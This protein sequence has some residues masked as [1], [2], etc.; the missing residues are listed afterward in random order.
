MSSKLA[1]HQP[2]SPFEGC[3]YRSTQIWGQRFMSTERAL[4]FGRALNEHLA[5]QASRV[6]ASPFDVAA[7]FVISNNFPLHLP[8]RPARQ[9]PVIFGSVFELTLY[10]VGLTKKHWGLAVHQGRALTFCPWNGWFL[11]QFAILACAPTLTVR[12]SCIPAFVR[13]PCSSSACP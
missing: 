2:Q 7:E 4:Y 12:P 6:S 13:Y 11:Q 1:L 10:S 3:I 5:R 9:L 8:R